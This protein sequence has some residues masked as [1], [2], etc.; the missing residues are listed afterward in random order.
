MAVGIFFFSYQLCES[1]FFVLLITCFLIQLKIG[2]LSFVCSSP[3]SERSAP[4]RYVAFTHLG[5]TTCYFIQRDTS[6]RLVYIF[7]R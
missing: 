7:S 5:E 2:I 6:L 4:L 1:V 3:I